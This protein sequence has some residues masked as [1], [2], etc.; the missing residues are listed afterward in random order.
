MTVYGTFTTC[1]VRTFRVTV[2]GTF[3]TTV[4]FTIVVHGTCSTT[5]RLRVTWRVTVW[6]GART[7]FRVVPTC[8][9]TVVQLHGSK[10]HS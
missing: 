5:V 9:C 10:Q 7:N 6:D 8:F 2:T 1:V 4:C 3:S